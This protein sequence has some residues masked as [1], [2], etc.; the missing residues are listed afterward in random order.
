MVHSSRSDSLFPG[1]TS[2]FFQYIIAVNRGTATSTSGYRNGG[3]DRL[4]IHLHDQFCRSLSRWP[5]LLHRWLLC[6]ARI[7]GQSDREE[8][9]RSSCECDGPGKLGCQWRWG[10]FLNAE[11]FCR[12]FKNTIATVFTADI[13]VTRSENTRHVHINVSL[14]KERGIVD[15]GNR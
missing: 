2:D 11:L 10:L 7:S 8:D 14:I 12:E 3:A 1:G 4:G 5:A 6:Q 15:S 13:K 9:L